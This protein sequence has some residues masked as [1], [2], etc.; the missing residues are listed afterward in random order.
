V[1]L[2]W[3]LLLSSS[4]D[5]D[6]A[7]VAIKDWSKTTVVGWP[8]NQQSPWMGGGMV[9][10]LLLHWPWRIWLVALIKV[11]ETLSHKCMT[12]GLPPWWS[13]RHFP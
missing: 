11:S 7:A 9:D 6:A 8:V 12:W 2:S 4:A 1:V 3:L 13:G 10:V 5:D